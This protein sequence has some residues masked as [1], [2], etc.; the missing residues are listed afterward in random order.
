MVEI[1]GHAPGSFC[2][3]DSGTDDL[4]TARAF[5]ASVFGWDYATADETGYLMCRKGSRRVAGLYRLNEDMLRMGAGP[6]WLASVAVADADATLAAVER[7]GGR[8][9]GPAFDVPGLGRAAAF[10]D[11]GGGLC[12]VWQATGHPGV[13]LLDEH[14]ALSWVELQ[15]RDPRP[16]ADFYGSVFGWA[17][18][19]VPMPGGAYHLFKD[20]ETS[21]A[22]MVAVPPQLGDVPSTWAVYFHVDDAD[23]A[24]AAALGAGGALITPITPI[25]T[26]GRFAALRSADGAFFS[27]LQAA[28][29]E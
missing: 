5:Y 17:L 27:V 13:G 3:V 12:G 20:G 24:V 9:V 1:G 22:G 21:R 4:A 2:W 16:A 15:V 6:Y 26:W 7:A 14:G 19:T 10:F 29:L 25:S 23:A 8:P 18:E 11:P 28:P